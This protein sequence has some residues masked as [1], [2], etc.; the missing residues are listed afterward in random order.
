MN[1]VTV[2]LGNESEKDFYVRIVDDEDDDEETIIVNYVDLE[3][4]ITEL[5]AA[6]RRIRGFIAV[7]DAEKEAGE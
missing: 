6:Q 5:T 2:Q 4:M 7:I 3:A 1:T